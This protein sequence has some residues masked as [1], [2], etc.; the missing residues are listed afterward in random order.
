MQ[1]QSSTCSTDHTTNVMRVTGLR[2]KVVFERCSPVVHRSC[3]CVVGDA[4]ATTAPAMG[5]GDEAPRRSSR[6]SPGPCAELARLNDVSFAACNAD[7]L[8]GA[9]GF[10]V[11]VGALARERVRKA[12]L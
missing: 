2:S 10:I 11:A 5:N 4:S 3:Q 6:L 9:L 8:D 1:H 7:E 12:E